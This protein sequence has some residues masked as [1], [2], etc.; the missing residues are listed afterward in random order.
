M[1]ELR[2]KLVDLVYEAHNAVTDKAIENRSTFGMSYS[3]QIET[4]TDHLIANGVTVQ[5][6]IS[7]TEWLPKKEGD[8]LVASTKGK[9]GYSHFF[10]EREIV[11][12]KVRDAV[13]CYPGVTHWMPLPEPP[14]EVPN[15]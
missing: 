3:E 5:Q 1:Y 11:P 7:V 2:E 6:W 9:V 14:K 15:V 8:Y 4:E 12:G 13:F 10:P